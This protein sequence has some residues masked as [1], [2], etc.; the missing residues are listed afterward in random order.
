[1]QTVK[2]EVDRENFPLEH[3]LD[4]VPITPLWP[5]MLLISEKMNKDENLLL[6]ATNKSVSTVA[7]YLEE[8]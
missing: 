5:N 7:T 2:V 1:M 6:C 8:K 3:E 4:H